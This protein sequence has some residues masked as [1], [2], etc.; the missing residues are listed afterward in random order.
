MLKK[1]PVYG[2][3]DL[4]AL[5]MSTHLDYLGRPLFMGIYRGAIYLLQH[6]LFFVVEIRST[7]AN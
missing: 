3:L 7:A 6:H 5:L 4:W 1:G 2:L